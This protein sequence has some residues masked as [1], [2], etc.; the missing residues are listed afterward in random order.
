MFASASI[1]SA[2]GADELLTALNEQLE[3]LAETF[4][5][6]VVGGSALLALG[7][8]ARATQDV[9]VVALGGKDGL[10]EA[11][12]LPEA[13][14]TARDRVARDFQLPD[15]W[16]NSAVA[17]DMLRLGLP[18]GLMQRTVT[19]RYGSAL[20]VHY[21]SR[22]DQIHLKLHATVD[23]GGGKHFADLRALQPTRDEL[24]AAARW[25]RTH[26][27]SEGFKEVLTEVLAYFE[28]DVAAL[29]T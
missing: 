3:A 2:D 13:L 26:D 17:R 10:Q 1:S 27:P 19:R 7:L 21:A 25:A 28:V 12:P 16:L 11:L 18:D 9:D 23:Q 8:V 29:G 15:E 6:V 14:R 22:V 4:E 5:L 20:T 24:L